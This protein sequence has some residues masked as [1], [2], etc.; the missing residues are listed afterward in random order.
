MDTKLTSSGKAAQGSPLLDF[1]EIAVSPMPRKGAPQSPGWVQP[2][3][4]AE[5]TVP[6]FCS[7]C[8]GPGANEWETC[9][10]YTNGANEW[11]TCC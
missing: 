11:A 5:S 7:E 10:D 8:E 6:E 9:E 2:I 3:P 4:V 1:S